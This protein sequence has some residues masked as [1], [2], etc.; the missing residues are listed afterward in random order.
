MKN[1]ITIK[2][3]IEMVEKSSTN[4]EKV[5]TEIKRQYLIWASLQF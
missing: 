2:E 3:I 1:D 5:N 4:F